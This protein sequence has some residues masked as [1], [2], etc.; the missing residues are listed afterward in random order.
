V[1]RLAANEQDESTWDIA[2][3]AEYLEHICLK[4]GDVKAAFDSLTRYDRDSFKAALMER[5][6]AFYQE[7]E[8]MISEIG[9]DMREFERVALLG[10]VD[11]R[12]MDHIDAMDQLREGIGLRA[13]GQKDPIVEYK[14][15]GYNM[16]EEMSRLIQEDTLRRLYMAVLVKPP[17]RKEAAVAVAATH[18]GSGA[19]SPRKPVKA[20]EKVGR[21]APCPCGSG[22][23]YKE[24]CGKGQ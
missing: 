18:G 14:I 20:G 8:K 17:E 11:R 7:R 19:A 1:D 4:P 23:K 15:E 16:F 10:A 6:I 12:W 3:L 13:Y 22:K 21:N 5:S 2:G 24:C 9:I